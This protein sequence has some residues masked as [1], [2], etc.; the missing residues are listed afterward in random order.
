MPFGKRFQIST[1]FIFYI[2]EKSLFVI[3]KQFQSLI[4]IPFCLQ[5]SIFIFTLLSN[6]IRRYNDF[7]LSKYL[8][9]ILTP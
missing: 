8:K 4:S 5:H 1:S 7:K 9:N 2:L 6:S 3:G